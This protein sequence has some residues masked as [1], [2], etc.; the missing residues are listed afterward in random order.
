MQTAT[1]LEEFSFTGD[2]TSHF[3]E[4]RDGGLWLPPSAGPDGNLPAIWELQQ[5]ALWPPLMAAQRTGS[6]QPCLTAFSEAAVASTRAAVGSHLHACIHALLR[7]ERKGAQDSTAPPT[8]ALLEDLLQWLRP[9]AFAALLQS[10]QLLFRVL[11]W[12]YGGCAVLMDASLSTVDVR[13]PLSLSFPRKHLRFGMHG[14]SN[15]G[16]LLR[17]MQACSCCCVILLSKAP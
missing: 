12:F 13:S 9:V 11:H 8:N 5:A 14:V 15:L 1:C 6:L 17:S 4:G 2:L 16:D 3:S 7:S 10:L